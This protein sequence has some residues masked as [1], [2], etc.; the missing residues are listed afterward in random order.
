MTERKDVSYLNSIDCPR[1]GRQV[2]VEISLGGYY[3]EFMTV[4]GGGYESDPWPTID[5]S[6]SIDEGRIVQRVEKKKEEGLAVVLSPYQAQILDSIRHSDGYGC[7]GD[8]E[9]LGTALNMLRDS[10][11]DR[12]MDEPSSVEVKE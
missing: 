10:I 2:P 8:S 6:L 4:L 5:I 9:I 3:E 7:S 11:R 1:C 12:E